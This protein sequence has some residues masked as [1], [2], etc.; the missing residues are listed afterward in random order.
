[1]PSAKHQG[2][3]ATPLAVRPEKTHNRYRA[4]P[5]LDTI[6]SEA[7]SHHHPSWAQRLAKKGDGRKIVRNMLRDTRRKSATDRFLTKLDI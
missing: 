2:N 3:S 4:N 6:L 5:A 1:V 7:Y